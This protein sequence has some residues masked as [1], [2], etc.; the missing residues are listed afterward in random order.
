MLFQFFPSQR[1][2]K[3]AKGSQRESKGAKGS[4]R[5]PKGA[6]AKGKKAADLRPR[7]LFHQ[8]SLA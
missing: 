6:V 2:P 4:Q 5:E 8:E 1:E 3:G 7:R